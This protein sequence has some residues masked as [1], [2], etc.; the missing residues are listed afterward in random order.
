MRIIYK[1]FITLTNLLNFLISLMPF[2]LIL[3]NLIINTN[4]VLIC[5]LGLFLYGKQILIIDDKIIKFL[6]FSFFSYIILITSYNNIP[7]IFNN[8]LYAK[9][10]YKSFFYLRFLFCYLVINKLIDE[11]KFNLKL[12]IYSCAFFSFIVAFDIIFQVIFEKNLI[13]NPITAN[14]PSSF[15]GEEHIAGGYL[16]KF[17]LFFLFLI[18]SKNKNELLNFLLFIIFFIPIILTANRMPAILYVESI[19]IFYFL[20]KNLK[21]IILF[22]LFIL[23]IFFLF[24]K[25]PIVN[26]IDKNLNSFLNETKNIVIKAPELFYYNSIE[27]NKEADNFGSTGYIVQFNSGVQTWKNNKI[28]GQGL[29][30]FPLK[31]KFGKN[32]VCSSHPH[33]YFI[34]I[35]LDVGIIGLILIYSLIIYG[36]YKYL[37]FFKIGEKFTII[38][39]PFFLIILLEFFPF[40]ASGSFF[41]TGNSSIIFLILPILFNI[42]KLEK[43]I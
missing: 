9:H 2:S 42:K 32:E 22:I 36:V 20:E 23:G 40:R 13:G 39:L 19:L 18:I 5:L 4:I 34:E 15:F 41:S 8:E 16:Q 43:F 17:V 30:S 3:G 6:I 27:D 7:H 33:N 25:F 10:F 14:R 11:N 12:F 31:C 21:K 26:R 1:D 37:I 24:I 35:M 28:F 29:R 38:T